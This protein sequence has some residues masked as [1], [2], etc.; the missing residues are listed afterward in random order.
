MN[1]AMHLTMS[2]EELEYLWVTSTK[3]DTFFVWVYKQ[4]VVEIGLE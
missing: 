2:S 3:D 4:L 1:P